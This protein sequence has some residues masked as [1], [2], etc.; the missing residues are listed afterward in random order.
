MS[1]SLQA[2]VARL[3]ER[4]NRRENALT[5]IFRCFEAGELC[6]YRN[7]SFGLEPIDTIRQSGESEA[8]LMVRAK[9]S[10]ALVGGVFVF[11]ELRR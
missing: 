8:E 2:K 10:A 7:A 5:V 11:R 4:I 6:G 3:E 1:R 9:S